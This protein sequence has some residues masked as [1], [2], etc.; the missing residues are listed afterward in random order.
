VKYWVALFCLPWILGAASPAA[1]I[2]GAVRDQYGDA[3]AGATVSAGGAQAVTSADGTF[4]LETTSQTV[5]IECAYCATAEAPVDADGIVVAIVQRYRALAEPAPSAADLQSLPYA[6]AESAIALAPFL[7]LNDSAKTLP[8][9]RISYYGASRFGGLLVDDGV[10]AYDIAA[11]ASALR[12]LPSYGVQDV[13]LLDPSDAFRYGDKAGGGT[14]FT[15]TRTA[16]GAAGSVTAGSSRAFALTQSLSGGAYAASLSNDGVQ[17][18]SRA[19]AWVQDAVADGTLGA[20][21][22]AVREDEE[23]GPGDTISSEM[24]AARVHYERNRAQ[25]FFAD[26]LADRAGYD[27]FPTAEYPVEG[28][29]SDVALESGISSTG[30]YGLFATAGIRASTGYYDAQA[31]GAE[32]VA[33]SVMQMHLSAGAQGH[34]GALSWRAG[35]G[36]FDIAYDGGTAG[37]R[38][39]M[40]AQAV[41]PSIGLTYA[42]SAQW[43]LT[44]QNDSSFR[45]PPLTK[46]YVAAP[47]VTAL[48]YDRYA[49]Q[50][51]ALSFSDLHRVHVS[52]V[53]L[54]R[55][56]TGLDNGPVN[57]AGASIAWQIAPSLSLRA[58]TLHTDDA[59]L[60]SRPVFRFGEPPLPATPAS[61]WLTYEDA[62]GIRVD[63]IWRNDLLD[64][65]ADPHF[66]A[67]V[68][69]PL[70]G[71]L[72][73]FAG[74]ERRQGVRYTSIGLR[75]TQF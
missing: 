13:T 21:F 61:L 20:Q 57:A 19:Q 67:S 38:R 23:G 35:I 69:G 27:A 75:Y 51:A 25:R 1:L 58:W 70:T 9:P 4:T 17:S 11:D 33:G 36:A 2:S 5:R 32:R 31:L 43:N 64:Y 15:G 34:S 52:L 41:E 37:S 63:A 39:P 8:G 49:T 26:A 53:A 12:T 48:E 7:V 28:Q 40:F 46:A 42:P 30:A 3:V 60:A 18:R 50:T 10:P 62:E 55:N 45:L 14:F 68:S 65:R 56:V 66:D 22:L 71:S 6:H 16:A 73:W 29:W 54:H 59:A 24:S 47:P 74:S 44:L 72:R